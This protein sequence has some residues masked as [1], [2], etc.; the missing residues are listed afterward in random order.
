MMVMAKA[1]PPT[2]IAI[3]KTDLSISIPRNE[4]LRSDEA[5]PVTCPAEGRVSTSAR[6]A[7]A[8]LISEG[9]DEL[10]CS[11]GKSAVGSCADGVGEDDDDDWALGGGKEVDGGG[12][13]VHVGGGG[14]MRGAGEVGTRVG[15]GG[16]RRDNGGGEEDAGD[17]DVA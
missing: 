1:Q 6:A 2:G 7:L 16:S 3:W 14:L 5:P 8:L 9:F 13:G 10:D 11:V 17:G 12:D 15:D 4:V